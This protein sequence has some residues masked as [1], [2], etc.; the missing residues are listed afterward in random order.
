MK[1]LVPVNVSHIAMYR[2]L[3]KKKYKTKEKASLLLIDAAIADRYTEFENAIKLNII[4]NLSEN[5]K[6]QADEGALRSCYSIST[7]G[8]KNILEGITKAQPT[9]Q[10]ER[11]PYCGTTLPKTHDHYLP[12]K[13]FPE[14]AVHGLNLV[15]CCSSC[16]ESKGDRWISGKKRIF[17]H[18][19]S[20]EIPSEIFLSVDLVPSPNEQTLGAIFKIIKPVSG[21]ITN[22][23]LIESHFSR[24]KL[25]DRYSELVNDEIAEAVDVCVDHLSEGGV[26]ASKFA[27]RIGIRMGDTFGVNHWRAVLYAA[28]SNHP[29]FEKMI[30][31]KLEHR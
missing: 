10:L 29:V 17:I 3:V 18:Y 1:N 27:R 9:R 4:H 7:V 8:L 21:V 14:L 24:L 28:L 13:E 20:D 30:Y 5:K 12:A 16:N 2:A 19:Y 31:L 23:D 15:P 22:W 6:L 25:L 26:S 11:C